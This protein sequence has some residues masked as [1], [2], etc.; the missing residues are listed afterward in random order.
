M[1]PGEQRGAPPMPLS[2]TVPLPCALTL[3]QE[4]GLGHSPDL[5]L[6]WAALEAIVRD[7]GFTGSPGTE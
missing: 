7:W 2:P 3:S 5:D 4:E 6:P 1:E